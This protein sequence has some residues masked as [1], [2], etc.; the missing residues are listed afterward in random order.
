MAIGV[1]GRFTV[2]FA[3]ENVDAQPSGFLVLESRF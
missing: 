1:D 2:L 3:E